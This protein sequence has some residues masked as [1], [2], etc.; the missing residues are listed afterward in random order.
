MPPQM[1]SAPPAPPAGLSSYHVP[2]SS[3]PLRRVGA[4]ATISTLLVGLVG[5]TGLF[6]TL[7]QAAVRDDARAFLA[8][9]IDEDEFIEAFGATALLGAL[10]SFLQLGAAI[11]TI[12]VMYR[13][14][15]NVRALGRTTTWAPGWA[16]G[17]WFVPPFVLYVIPFLMWR[18]LWKASDPSVA[19]GDDRWKQGSVP[20]SFT[21]WWVLF[22]L[23][24]IALL[25]GQGA[26]MLGGGLTAG[27]TEALAESLVDQYALTVA[28][29]VATFAAAIAFVVSVRSLSARHR[30]LTGERPGS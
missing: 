8:G 9:T 11:T 15:A 22:G 4:L 18:E 5:I 7:T 26:A 25:V 24:P 2:P 19:A 16:I 29:G 3:A 17:G 1:P 14:A 30:S 28:G 13:F 21:I 27:S 12:I 6:G 10:T 23:V 20:V